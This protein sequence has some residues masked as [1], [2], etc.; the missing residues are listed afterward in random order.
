MMQLVDKLMSVQQIKA[1]QACMQ[2]K[3]IYKIYVMRIILKVKKEHV[4][5]TK[6]SKRKILMYT[7]K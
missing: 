5:K 7:D 6:Q 2:T 1:G 3:L 4:R